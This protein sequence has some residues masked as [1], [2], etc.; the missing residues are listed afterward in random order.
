MSKIRNM[1]KILTAFCVLSAFYSAEA[2]QMEGK[3]VY[4]RTTQLQLRVQG[5]GDEAER[6]I[7]RS[8]TDKLEVLFGNNQSLRRA[9]EDD[10]PE[11]SSFEGNGMVIRT[12]GGGADDVIYNNF[13][14]GV[15]IDQ[16]EFGGKTYVIA[17]SIKKLDWKLTG[18]TKSILGYNCQK[19]VAFRYGKRSMV[20]M[21]NGKME[22]RE[23]NDTSA[24]VVWFTPSVPVPVAPEFQGQLPGLILE[25][26]INKG[27]IV[28]KAVEVAPKVNLAL[29]R[30]PKSGKR[31]TQE[32]FAK[33]REKVLQDM[34]R[35]GGGAGR[36]IRIAN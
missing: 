29:I 31:V 32:E 30:E 22:R 20:E 35:N 33:E 2:Q 36:T 28:Y 34:Q 18:E 5:M 8:R 26:D 1:K 25:A 13:A 27:N 3:V 15:Q 9:V 19:A 4:E 12:F 6:M 17:D 16:R 7:P 21:N 23:V 24:I 11:P 10:T 14:Q